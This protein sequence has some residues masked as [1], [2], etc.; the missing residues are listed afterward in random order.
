M[1]TDKVA[2]RGPR[3]ARYGHRA[4][5]ALA[6]I[7]L[8]QLMIILDATIVNVALPA[9]QADLGFSSAALSWVLNAY[10]LTFGGLLLLGGRAGD[11]LGRR[12]VFVV[13]IVVFTLAS[14]AGGFA[15]EAWHLVAARFL[16]GVGAALASPGTLALIATTFADGP[17]RNKAMAIYGA[18]GGGGAAIGL[19]LGGVLTEGA[20]WRWVL[21][22]NVPIGVAL[23]VLAPL[24]ITESEQTTG[25]FDVGGAVTS[26]LGMA[27]LVYGFVSV[28]TDGW[29][30]SRTL[31]AFVIGIVLLGAY[32]V[33][34][35]RVAQPITPLRLFADRN[36]A[37]AYGAMFTVTGSLTGM[38]FFLTQFVQLVLDFKPLVAGL[39]F[40]PVAIILLPAAGVVTKLLPR[41]G[42]KPLMLFGS[43]LVAG[44][45][46]WLSRLSP[47]SSY[48]T[49]ILG[50]IL[51]FG[52]GVAFLTIPV[53]ILAVGEVRPEDAGA[54]SSLINAVQ[55]V[56]GA[57]GLAILVTVF[58]RAGET[59]ATDPALAGAADAILAR[60]IGSAFSAATVF[61]VVTLLAVL[62]VKSPD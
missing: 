41:F 46:L 48:V 32:L 35:G 15:T 29:T 52:I 13:G 2:V 62:L 4:G 50:P 49:G 59:A 10:T 40:V 47:T 27:S 45:M 8:C 19:I 61:A 21:F 34:E 26:T 28:T 7:V 31:P 30:G 1:S 6:V 58:D 14:F 44:G 36:R 17:A 5:V 42:P 24:F 3:A 53:T 22:V 9:I 39:S 57:L 11:I 25:E 54:A 16:Q 60:G 56:G 43:A 37:A 23:T 18:V 12:R 55:Q 51:V 20:S 33:L 38:F